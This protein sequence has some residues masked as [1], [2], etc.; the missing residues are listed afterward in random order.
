[1]IKKIIFL[2]FVL[3]LPH[4]TFADEFTVN[5]FL[6]G[7]PIMGYD[8]SIFTWSILDTN[9]EEY[10]NFTPRLVPLSWTLYWSWYTETLIFNDLSIPFMDYN[11]YLRRIDVLLSDIRFALISLLM[12]YIFFNAIPLMRSILYINKK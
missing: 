7:N 8:D 2:L 3:L 9:I 10:T 4:N 12:F 11:W 5:A 1:M 6:S